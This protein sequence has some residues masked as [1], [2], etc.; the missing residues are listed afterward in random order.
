MLILVRHLRR[1]APDCNDFNGPHTPVNGAGD[2]PAR[3]ARPSALRA[4]R[5]RAL[6]IGGAASHA[7]RCDLQAAR[8]LAYRRGHA[9]G[10]IRA[11][12]LPRLRRVGPEPALLLHQPPADVERAARGARPTQARH[13]QAQKC[14]GTILLAVRSAS[15][16]NRGP[17][18]ARRAAMWTVVLSL[19]QPVPAHVPAQRPAP[20]EVLAAWRAYRREAAH[21]RLARRRPMHGNGPSAR[22][23]RV[24]VGIETVY[25]REGDGRAAAPDGRG[26]GF[27]ERRDAFE[28]VGGD[29]EAR[30]EG[31]ATLDPAVGAGG[32]YAVADKLLSHF[33]LVCDV[34]MLC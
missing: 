23:V 5:L 27:G 19:P 2:A 11:L 9:S 10:K 29:G 3:P 26:E 22:L 28:S 15:N 4:A 6:A 8:A 14:V 34:L 20:D 24:G 25:E 33:L 1:H 30:I 18:A 13:L 16:G 31:A 7:A 21:Q 17:V 12:F 32:R